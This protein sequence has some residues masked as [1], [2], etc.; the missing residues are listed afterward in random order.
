MIPRVIHQIWIG[1]KKQPECMDLWKDINPTF[2]YI[3]W[4]EDK[5]LAD[6]PDGLYNQTQFDHYQRLEHY[7]GQANVIR[8]ELLFRYGG[9]YLDADCIPLRPLE[10]YLLDNEF[11]S[12]FE[13]EK[14]CGQLVANGV[15]GC[16]PGNKILRFMIDNLHTRHLDQPS[17][18]ATGPSYLTESLNKCDNEIYTIYPS[19]YF[20]PTHHTGLKY[21]GEFKPFSDHFWGTTKSRY[22]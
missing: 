5:L 4:T 9:I 16:C 18:R 14:V 19:H 3:L 6:F 15:I 1:P 17:W 7:N 8:L 11:F 20:L 13:N 22:Q 10:D 2:D 12:V 21:D